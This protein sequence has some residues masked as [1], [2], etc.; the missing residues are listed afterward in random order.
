MRSGWGHVPPVPCTG[1][2]GG[3]RGVAL[4]LLLLLEGGV[5]QEE[6]GGDAAAVA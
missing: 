3:V 5:V 6:E 4:L 1:H 2:G